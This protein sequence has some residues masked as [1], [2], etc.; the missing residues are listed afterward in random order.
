MMQRPAALSSPQFISKGRQAA[1][2]VDQ[3]LIGRSDLSAIKLF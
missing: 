3:F 2:G 1:R